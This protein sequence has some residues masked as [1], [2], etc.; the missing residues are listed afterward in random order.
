[1]SGIINIGVTALTANQNALQTISNN[2]ANVNTPGYTRQAVVLSN[3]PGQFTGSGYYG[4]GVETLTVR[5]L[6]DEFLTRQAATSQAVA[7]SDATRYS[8][9]QQLE[10][11]FPSGPNGLGAS[12]SDMLNAYSDITNAPTD[13]TARA[14]ALARAD[15]MAHRFRSTAEAINELRMGTTSQLRIDATAINNLAGQIAKTNEQI[16][17]AMGSGH[18]PNDLLD[19]RDQLIRD[20][21]KYVQTT[22][23]KADDGSLS[24]FLAG[25]QPLVLGKTVS[26]V[27]VVED[28]FGDPAKVKLAIT[29][30]GV[31]RILEESMLGGGEVAGLLRFQNT[32]L[33]DASNLLGRMALAIGTRMNEQQALGL[34][35]NG[36]AGNPLFNL[37]AIADGYA[38]SA[39]TGGATL[40]VGI[41]ANPSGTTAFLSSN[42]EFSFATATTGTITRLSDGVTTAFDFGATN[43]VLLDGFEILRSGPAA[44]A[45][46]RF[47]ITPFATAARGINTAFSSPKELAMASPIA[48]QAGITNTGALTLQGLAVRTVPIPPA[49]T[50]TFTGP[51]TYTRSDTGATV[52]NY[53]PGQPIEYTFP[54]VAPLTGWSLTLKGVPQTGDTYTVDANPYPLLDGAN[55]Q[56]ML[57]L[58]DLAMFDGGPLTDGYASLI[59]EIGTKVQGAEQASIVSGNI[60][61]NIEKDRT[62]VAGVNLDEEAARM[63]QFQQAYQ[64]AGKMMQIAQNIFDT[65]LASFS[66]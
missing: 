39:N 8:Y 19:Q 58:R 37:S 64:A 2:I 17:I 45:G 24:I 29:V 3:I 66:R 33:V 48:A 15:E 55:A 46:D 47:V 9:M 20:L 7:S 14:V 44:A 21:N 52:H 65:L 49:V 57:D 35:L 31:P 54:A 25:S 13:L 5:R 26:P 16:A 36:N 10:S 61:V 34:D 22:N 53:V 63:I 62:A 59:A 56:A 28:E 60:A 12:V 50:L 27:S 41:Q 30:G 40:S 43:P 38:S 42:Y 11:L 4:K 51:G 23:I 6:Y 32:D 1:M 18:T